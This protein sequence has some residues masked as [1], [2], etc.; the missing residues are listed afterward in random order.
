VSITCGTA[1]TKFSYWRGGKTVCWLQQKKQSVGY[2]KKKQSVGYS[3]KNSLLVTAK[4]SSLLVAAKQAVCWLQQKNSLLVT[5]KK[6][7]CWLQQKNSLLITAKK[8]HNR[9]LQLK[10]FPKDK[11]CKSESSDLIFCKG[12][13]TSKK[14][15]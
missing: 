1:T 6:A 7:V 11:V 3:K 14:K 4:K 2:S 13:K 10:L 8:K 15:T 9:F 12:L 5:A